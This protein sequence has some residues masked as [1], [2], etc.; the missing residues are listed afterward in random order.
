MKGPAPLPVST[1]TDRLLRGH[2]INQ[3]RRGNLPKSIVVRQTAL[4]SFARWLEPRTLL[5][6]TR[7]DIETFLDGRKGSEGRALNGRTRYA[8]LSHFHAFYMQC[9]NEELIVRDPTLTI[10]RPKIRRTLPRPIEDEDLAQALAQAPPQ[11]RAI[12]A[13][14]CFGGL[15]C[16][17][18]A[19]L[20]RDDVIE[21]KGL[22]R[23]VNGK[24]GHERVLP[25]HPEALAALRCLPMPRTGCLFSRPMGG[26]YS[27][28]DM[29]VGIA[30]YLR[31]IGI[32][33]TA[34]QCRHWYATGVYA[35]SHDIRLVQELLG[36]QS[37]TTT[38]IY[39]A[40]SNIEATA[41][42]GA[43]KLGA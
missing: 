2:L 12:L 29:S 5:E 25:L 27:P 21:A 31:S 16:Q 18:L 32:A 11:M 1:E 22:L 15:R 41:A 33:A 35:A 14:A 17:E 7:D 36:H 30:D 34:H 37:P 40:F 13:L 3:E 6:A 38:A 4:R 28:N 23:V 26:R 24:G 9:V 39:V 43:L 20:N 19:G 10:V 42:V 8:W